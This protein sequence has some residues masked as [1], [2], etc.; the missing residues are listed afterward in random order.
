MDY[1]KIKK[2]QEALEGFLGELT[3]GGI[4]HIRDIELMTK[5][6][7]ALDMLQGLSEGGGN[8]YRRGRSYDGGNSY[9]G[10][11]SNRRSYRSYDDGYSGHDI[12]EA[13]REKIEELME[14]ADSEKD[15][16]IAREMLAKL[17]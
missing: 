9:D 17:R 10:G 7:Y 2:A 11:M 4:N 3:E 14:S 16:R 8:S 1:E 12:K 15:R 13:M 6:I 5:T